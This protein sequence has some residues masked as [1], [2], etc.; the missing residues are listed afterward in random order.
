MSLA[1]EKAVF[2]PVDGPAL[3]FFDFDIPAALL[4]VLWIH[5]RSHRSS[6]RSLGV[7]DVAML[8]RPS[9]SSG[10]ASSYRVTSFAVE[11]RRLG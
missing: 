1:R 2:G 4:P 6:A 10:V 7:H 8:V 5:G 9:V 11:S 3:A